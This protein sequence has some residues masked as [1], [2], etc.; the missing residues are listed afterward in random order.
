[1]NCQSL[2][3]WIVALAFAFWATPQISATKEMARAARPDSISRVVITYRDGTTASAAAASSRAGKLKVSAVPLE[4]VKS[5]DEQTQVFRLGGR[6]LPSIEFEAL[7]AELRAKDSRIH[8]VE[9]DILVKRQLTPTDPVYSLAQWHLMQ[10]SN[11]SGNLGGANFPLAWDITQGQGVVVAV[12]DTGYISH[13]DLSSNLYLPGYDFISDAAIA[14]DGDGRDADATDNGDWGE[15][16]ECDA[17]S[18]GKNTTLQ[19]SSWHGGHVAG[20]IAAVTN[21]GTGVAGGAFAAKVLPVRAL[22]RCGSGFL[23]DIA[24]GVRWAAGGNVPGA[25][26]NQVAAKVIN[27][28]LGAS[29]TSC[30]SYMQRAVD[31][32][33]A[34]GSV[35]IAATGNDG[36]LSIGTPANCVGVLAVTAHTFQGDN[37]DY[38]NVGTGTGISAPGGGK[39]TQSDSTTF[40]CLTANTSAPNFSIAS[41]ALY[42]QRGPTSTNAAGTLSGPAYL[43][44]VGTSMAAPHV[45]AAAA[46]LLSR[47][48]ALAIPL[49]ESQIRAALRS[50]A[51]PFPTGTWCTGYSDGRCGDGMLDAASA[52]ALLNLPRQPTAAALLPLSRSATVGSTVTVFATLINGGA[53]TARACSISIGS[54][55]FVGDFWFQTTNPLT[56]ALVGS[57]NST[58]DIAPGAAQSFV[59]GFVP[60]STLSPTDLPLRFDCLNASEVPTRTGLNTLLLSASLS[61]VPDVI[62]LAATLNNDGIVNIPGISGTGAFAVATSNVGASGTINASADTGGAL[63]PIDLY[64]CQTNASTGAC[65]TPPAASATATITAGATPTFA[66]FAA[67]RGSVAFAPDSN[68]IFVRFRDSG[69]AIRGATSVAVRTQ[70]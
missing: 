66:V 52:L 13:P 4:W 48:T 53:T 38:A 67:G 5:L 2:K 64:I 51:R 8:A 20:T 68:R 40:T 55:A 15:I 12:V 27:L 10:T 46:L 9:A 44:Y 36:V 39:C 35:V 56:N 45:S 34:L 30:P 11:P 19:P 23:S 7:S 33:R 3:P 50:S 60:T 24:D 69:N 26:A 31:Q 47:A 17:E 61:A 6:P 22:G 49:S 43:G 57:R 18:G 54:T 63:L 59:L 42:G 28:S 58:V 29:G 14:H 65:L 41:T 37:A 21:N 32:A 70:P 1:M 62:A 16:G 25:A